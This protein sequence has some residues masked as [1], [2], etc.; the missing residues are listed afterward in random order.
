M[1]IPIW[2]LNYFKII[3]FHRL[4]YR[5][6]CYSTII[7]LMAI[8]YFLCI[9]PF[10]GLNIHNNYYLDHCQCVASLD[11][12]F[13]EFRFLK[14]K[15]KFEYYCFLGRKERYNREL[16][17]KL[18][19]ITII[20]NPFWADL[21]HFP[22]NGKQCQI[23]SRHQNIYWYYWYHLGRVQDLGKIQIFR[24]VSKISDTL[25]IDVYTFV[26]KYGR[27]NASYMKR[28][29]TDVVPNDH[30]SLFNL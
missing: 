20:I 2:R 22:K 29:K 26:V 7:L 15:V 16:H 1:T 24:S 30:A 23:S 14:V 28:F 6:K 17:K 10:E 3:T 4:T 12:C 11:I 8:F 5:L 27:D 18:Y 21:N 13:S 19:I 25:H 9:M